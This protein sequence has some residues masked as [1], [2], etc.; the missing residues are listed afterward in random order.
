MLSRMLT[1]L[2]NVLPG[3]G[4]T[5][6]CGTRSGARRRN[7]GHRMRWRRVPGHTR[8]NR[9]RS[10]SGCRSGC[11][12][13]ARSWLRGSGNGQLRRN[14]WKIAQSRGHGLA[15]TR[16]NLTGLGR[17]NRPRGNRR[18]SRDRR[19]QR[20]AGRRRRKRRPQRM[21]FR[22]RGRILVRH[23]F[24]DFG[25]SLAIGLVP[26]N[27]RDARS[28]FRGGL[29]ARFPR[30]PGSLVF[31]GGRRLARSFGRGRS[32]SISARA[33]FRGDTAAH[34]ERDIV[35]ER[36]RVCLFVRHAEVAQQI[37]DHI[38]LDLKLASQLVNADFTHT[39][40]PLA[41]NTCAGGLHAPDLT[42]HPNL[43]CSLS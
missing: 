5:G 24:G 31:D 22:G 15:R 14:S 42:F 4:R 25:A 29:F 38:G 27:F 13:S 21:R 3:R 18:P 11:V 34:F 26:R 30:G 16:N 10:K 32:G 33:A 19:S 1:G 6:R 35:V 43:P 17:G 28:G 8:L 23:F 20:K 2:P 12:N 37:D 36:T 39:V 7:A 41:Q 9:S 40:M